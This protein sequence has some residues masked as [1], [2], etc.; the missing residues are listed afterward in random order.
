M[1]VGFGPLLAVPVLALKIVELCRAIPVLE[2]KLRPVPDPHATLLGRIDEEQPT[3]RPECLRA[4]V[5]PIFLFN[6]E[7]PLTGTCEFVG[8]DEAGE[9]GTDHQDVG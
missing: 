6:D 4:K 7:N 2:G 1:Y 3:E 9:S 8:G 5:G